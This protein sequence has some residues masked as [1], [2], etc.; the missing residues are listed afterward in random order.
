MM[1]VKFSDSRK[2]GFTLIELLVVIAIIAILAA[3]LFPV[4]ARARENAR[5][6][7]CQSNEKQI[8]LGFK[9]YIQDNNERYPAASGWNT[10]ILDYTK[11]EAILKCPSAAGAGTFDYSYNSNMGGKNEN[12][13]DN[14][15]STILVAEATR[16]G[17]AT[18]AASA[19]ASSRHFDG[20]NYAFVDGHVKWIKGAV[21]ATDTTGSVPTFFVPAAG[22]STPVVNPDVTG[23]KPQNFEL[24]NLIDGSQ[25]PVFTDSDCTTAVPCHMHAGTAYVTIGIANTSAAGSGIIYQVK[26]D[27]EGQQFANSGGGN[28]RRLDPGESHVGPGNGDWGIASYS[29]GS[30]SG[31]TTRIG[32]LQV[33]LDGGA[34]TYTRKY[35]IVFDLP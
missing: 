26:W 13:V 16:S 21:S 31:T 20:S 2:S 10:A 8:A 18:S 1:N 35:H 24:A 29:A 4:F 34:F 22:G 25:T 17:G 15:A 11:S 30:W 7:S 33:G 32:T 5:R 19:S 23:T 6:S 3:I 28:P 14:T 27:I 12:K 9:Q